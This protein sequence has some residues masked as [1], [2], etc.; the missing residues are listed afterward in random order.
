MRTGILLYLIAGVLICQISMEASLQLLL[1]CASGAIIGLALY[2]D[3]SVA[4]KGAGA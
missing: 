2:V 4:K 3:S 1:C